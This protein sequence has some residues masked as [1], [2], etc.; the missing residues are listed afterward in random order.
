MYHPE[1]HATELSC[2]SRSH[3]DGVMDPHGECC[4]GNVT[5]PHERRYLWD[6]P[7]N[8]DACEFHT[9]REVR[10]YKDRG[11]HN[12]LKEAYDKAH[13]FCVLCEAVSDDSDI[14]EESEPEES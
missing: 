6:F 5:K 10:R 13:P 3:C 12:C 7:D 11:H 4:S 9:I 14:S 8:G 2:S 1:S